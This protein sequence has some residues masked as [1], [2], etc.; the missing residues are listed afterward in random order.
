MHEGPPPW[1]PYFFR[2]IPLKRSWIPEGYTL[3]VD[4]LSPF[5]NKV[6]AMEMQEIVSS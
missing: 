5:V 6:E 4:D 3:L 1:F 2:D